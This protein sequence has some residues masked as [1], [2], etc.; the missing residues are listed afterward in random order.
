M[1]SDKLTE[2]II[3]IMLTALGLSVFNLV[4][5]KYVSFLFSF[6]LTIIDKFGG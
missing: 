2:C 3:D 6:A 4:L 1:D 5:S